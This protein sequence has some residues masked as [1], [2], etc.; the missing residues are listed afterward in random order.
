MIT[1]DNAAPVTVD[2]LPELPEGFH[3]KIT[4]N[5]NAFKEDVVKT[6]LWIRRDL[7]S[8]D[9]SQTAVEIVAWAN[10]TKGSKWIQNPTLEELTRA[11]EGLL[12]KTSNRWSLGLPTD[13]AAPEITL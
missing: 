13:L 3:W 12:A 5:P 1:S 7:Q 4:T 11:A 2:Q 8:G 6:Y 10:L 9:D